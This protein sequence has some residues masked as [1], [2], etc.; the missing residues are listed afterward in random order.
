MG[1]RAVPVTLHWLGV[2][3]C[4]DTG[5][6]YV[7]DVDVFTDPVQ[8]PSGNPQLVCHFRRANWPDLE[9]PL[10]RH[11]LCVDVF[12]DYWPSKNLVRT[13]AAVVP[14]LRGW[15]SIVRPSERLEAVEERVLLLDAEPHVKIGVLLGRLCACRP[16]VRGVR[17][18]VGKE[19]FA[20]HQDVVAA[21]YRVWAGE[22]RP[23]DTVGILAGRLVRTRAVEAPDRWLLPCWHYL[24]LG[25]E[26]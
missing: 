22:H 24:A 15:E 17:G 7:P 8:Q 11:H 25:T 6:S 13:H 20:H 2:Q 16:G 4:A 23:Q 21:S 1:S 19:D 14:A 26:L 5:V 12:F 10:S 9:L 18:E 3:R